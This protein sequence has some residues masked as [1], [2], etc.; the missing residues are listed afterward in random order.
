VS[1]GLE[2]NQMR[3]IFPEVE[4]ATHGKFTA[5]GE[6]VIRG[7]LVE[8]EHF[9]DLALETHSVSIDT[10]SV[11]SNSL[12]V[13]L[14]GQKYDAHNF[15]SEVKGKAL[16]AVVEDTTKAPEGLICVQVENTLNALG[17]L[18]RYHRNRFN[19][20]VIGVTGS[21]G[22]TTT[23]AFLQAALS[24]LGDIHASRENFN[25]EIGVP[26]TL[27]GLNES[28]KAAIVEMGMRG[29]G[30]I[31][32]L[33]KIA[34]PTIG[35]IT[36]IG[37]QHIELLGSLENVARAKAELIEQLP[38]D[39]VAILPSEGDYSEL[40]LQT[41]QD[42]GCRIVTF[43]TNENADFRVTSTRS[44]NESVEIELVTSD[45]SSPVTFTLPLPGVHNATNAAAA[46]AVAHELGVDLQEAACALETVD[47]PGARMRVR[48][49]NEITVLDD[50]YNAGPNS[51]RAALETLRDWQNAKRRVAVLGTMK[52]LG[53][54]SEEE[55]RKLI[56]TTNGCCD[57]IIGVGEEMS[58]ALR[59]ARIENI[60]C[61]DADEAAQRVLDVVQ[62]GDVV[63]VKGS[64]SV[65]LE[66]VV[67]KLVGA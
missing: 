42:M 37:P 18:A 25:N 6:I 11:A 10:R 46:L 50:C 60:S 12:F 16:V 14:R 29:S 48:R 58:A 24:P 3:L 27:F 63:L 59:N 26:Q 49:T 52:E 31:E 55:H 4:N 30:Q 45:S 13:A 1:N 40:L 38:Q 39:G 20:P 53:D 23:R 66:V 65:G 17:D 7:E 5:N 28:H 62:N 8:P 43:G 64:R 35:V 34:R 9:K 54:F 2:Q 57:F 51:M 41:A 33:A 44:V 21:Y 22:K 36:N 61:A 47:V 15:L 32:Y 19:I 67:Q 56:E